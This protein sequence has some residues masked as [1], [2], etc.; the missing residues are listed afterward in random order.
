MNKVIKVTNFINEY[1]WYPIVD[2]FT[3]IYENTK[4]VF[5]CTTIVV[6]LVSIGI[7]ILKNIGF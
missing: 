3:S 7:K 2:G 4:Y 1:I 5:A 6:L